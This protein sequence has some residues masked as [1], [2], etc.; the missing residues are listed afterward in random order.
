[1]DE[2]TT[3]RHDLATLHARY[4]ND[5]A[6]LEQALA[7]AS[8]E[9]SRETKRGLLSGATFGSFD[10]MTSVAGIVFALASK[11]TSTIVLAAIGLAVASCV[12]M[13]AGEYLGDSGGTGKGLRAAVMGGATTFGTLVPALPFILF[14]SKATAFAVAGILALIL[15]TGIGRVRNQ[16]VKGYLLTYGIMA[17]AILATVGV[18]LAIPSSA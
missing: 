11:S 5:V 16:G 8:A 18:S 7:A 10:G 4:D 9:R 12:G 2:L 17:A 13:A 1:M 6:R 14:S 3:L 15:T